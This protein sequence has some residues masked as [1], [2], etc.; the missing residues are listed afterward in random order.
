MTCNLPFS[1]CE[2]P[3]VS[4]YTNLKHISTETRLQYGGLV[5]RQVEV[6][7]GLTLS[8]QFGIMFDGW[9]FQS[10]PDFASF[11]HN[12]RADKVLLAFV[13]LI[14]DDVTDHT[15]ASHVKVWRESCL[16]TFARLKM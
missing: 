11:Q 13:P 16:F 6:D 15:S 9:T 8:V 12:G 14:D 10:E 5:M 4:K 7:V 3:F 1:W 2:D